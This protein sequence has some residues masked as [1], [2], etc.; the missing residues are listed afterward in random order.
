MAHP[1]E[2]LIIVDDCG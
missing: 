2:V 1:D